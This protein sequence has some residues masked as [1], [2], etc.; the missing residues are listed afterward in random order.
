MAIDNNLRDVRESEGISLTKLAEESAISDKTIRKIE[1][2][3]LSK[4]RKTTK[5]RILKGLN[6]LTEKRYA[7]EDIFPKG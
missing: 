1:T 6:K 4:A 3:K 7:Y 5:A 2:R